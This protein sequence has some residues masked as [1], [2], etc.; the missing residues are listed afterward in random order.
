MTATP[1]TETTELTAADRAGLAVV[2]HRPLLVSPIDAFFGLHPGD[3]AL[4]KPAEAV[5]RGQP[6]IEH[7]RDARTIATETPPPSSASSPGEH[8]G[9]PSGRGSRSGHNPIY[10]SFNR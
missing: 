2:R 6:I 9:G 3:R 4:V 10:R 1:L 5:G 8:V 7:Y